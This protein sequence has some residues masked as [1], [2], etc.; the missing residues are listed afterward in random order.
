MH[1]N[2]LKYFDEVA[3]QG[4]IRKA[5]THLNV[6]STSVNR[7]IISTEKSL[8]VQ[9]F[10][11][12]S[13]GVTLTH[14]GS[15]VLDHCRQT[16][17]DYDRV[18]VLVDQIRDMRSGHV[19]VMALDSVAV[20][21]L[22]DALYRFSSTYPEITC[23]VVTAQPDEIMAAVGNGEA[24]IGLSFCLDPHPSVRILAE[25]SSPIGAVLPA[26]HP[27]A[28]RGKLDLQDLEGHHLI[29]S[30]DARSGQSIID[31]TL[32]DLTARLDARTFTNSL[33]LA[34]RLILRGSG[35]GLYTKLGFLQEIDDGQLE[36]VPIDLDSLGSLKLGLL[37]SSKVNIAPITHL[38]C[39]ELSKSLKTV[40]LDS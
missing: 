35:I 37:V 3:R 6:S 33:P 1:S 4:S 30:I 26:N 28:Q 16:L 8:G 32:T 24:D 34:R 5:A 13:E 10:N 18:Q 27:L 40:R 11:R 7:K 31:Q 38:L 20:G 39:N 29:R 22:P 15:V 19:T 12:T 36:F 25:K 21:I 14:A 17:F 2:F 9:L 23:S